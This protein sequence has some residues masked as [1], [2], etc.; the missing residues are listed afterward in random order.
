MSVEFGT[1]T[2]RMDSALNGLQEEFKSLCSIEDLEQ[3]MEAVKAAGNRSD[4]SSKLR[5][6]F[7]L[8]DLCGIKYERGK[9]NDYYETIVKNSGLPS[10]PE[11]E[12]TLFHTPL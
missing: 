9:S 8:F 11:L 7:D 6:L 2:R 5:G 4:R 1:I 10:F 3:K 12:D